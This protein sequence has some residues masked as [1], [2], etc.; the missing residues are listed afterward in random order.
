VNLRTRLAAAGR[1]PVGDGEVNGG[2]API[3]VRRLGFHG[4]GPQPAEAV[5]I[6]NGRWFLPGGIGDVPDGFGLPG[7]AVHIGMII[8]VPVRL[9]AERGCCHDARARR[10]DPCHCPAPGS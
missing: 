4:Y 7:A 2:H 5:L 6:P 10:A 1:R 3:L 8:A 9:P